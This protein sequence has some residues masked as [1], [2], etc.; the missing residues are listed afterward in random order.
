MGPSLEYPAAPPKQG[1]CKQF[2]PSTYSLGGGAGEIVGER[3]E[4]GCIFVARGKL[5]S[6][7]RCSTLV[8]FGY[9]LK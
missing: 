1:A 3:L 4:E 8:I 6:L 5:L 9:F 2:C 7:Q